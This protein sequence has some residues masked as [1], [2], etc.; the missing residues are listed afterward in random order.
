LFYNSAQALSVPDFD[1]PHVKIMGFKYPNKLF[2][3]ALRF[4][5][6]TSIDKLLGGVDLFIMPNFLFTHLS[7][8][9]KKLI[10][11]HDLSFELY[12]EFFTAK[13]RLWH[14]LI[15]PRQLC[16]QADALLAISANTKQ[17]LIDFY[18]IIPKKITVSHPGINQMYFESISDQ[19]KRKVKEKYQLPNDY[20][21]YLGN[22][23]PRKNLAS[24]LAAFEQLDQA[25]FNLVIAGGQ[26]WKYKNLYRLWQTSGKKEKIKFLG[27]VDAADKPAL[28]AQAKV[29]VYPSIYE[30]FGLP[31]LEA[32]ACGLPVVT[33]FASSLPEAIADAGL[34]IDPNNITDLV[35]AIKQILTD[36]QLAQTLSQRGKARSQNFGW[37]RPAQELLNLINRL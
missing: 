22:L 35:T 30:G 2:N 10:I 5:K 31:P 12:P 37:Q 24:L 36:P 1:F 34:M 9:C 27:Y 7:P 20:I 4:L 32:M 14:R 26:A 8:K 19:V 18:K 25:K 13:K 33:S 29:F 6:I 16:R 28:Y 3:L 23:E 15:N 11:V 17:D 21:F